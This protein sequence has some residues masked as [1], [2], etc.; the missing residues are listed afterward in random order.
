LYLRDFFLN[1]FEDV[2]VAF[3]LIP[4]DDEECVR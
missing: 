1:E 4:F 3:Y 2:P